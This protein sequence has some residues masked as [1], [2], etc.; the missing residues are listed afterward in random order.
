[1]PSAISAHQNHFFWGP[2]DFKGDDLIVLQWGPRKLQRYCQVSEMLAEHYHPY[3]M[4]EENGPIYLCRG[5]RQ[6][7]GEIWPRLKLWN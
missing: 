1:M 2:P 7:L 4:E 3:G 6:P 5:L